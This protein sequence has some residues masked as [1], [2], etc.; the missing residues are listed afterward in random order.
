MYKRKRVVMV[1]TKISNQDK[2]EKKL[3][4]FQL[5]LYLT[6]IYSIYSF[7]KI[8]YL[9]L[10]LCQVTVEFKKL[11]YLPIAFLFAN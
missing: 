10:E 8:T 5:D 4:F 6:S 11:F 7:I 1:T 2:N 3:F 9:T